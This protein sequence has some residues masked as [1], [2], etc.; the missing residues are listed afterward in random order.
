MSILHRRAVDHRISIGVLARVVPRDLVDEV[1]SETGSAREAISSSS[2]PIHDDCRRIFR[3]GLA[4]FQDGA[5]D[6]GP[7]GSGELVNEPFSVVERLC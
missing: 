4:I 1:L 3:H 7:Q 2:R 6:P 5:R